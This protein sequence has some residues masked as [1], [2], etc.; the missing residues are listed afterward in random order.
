MLKTLV[1]SRDLEADVKLVACINV[2][3]QCQSIMLWGCLN[4]VLD[5]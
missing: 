4:F 5:I 2:I 3:V 1:R